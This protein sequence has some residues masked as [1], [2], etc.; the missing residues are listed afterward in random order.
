[1]PPRRPRRGLSAVEQPGHPRPPDLRT[2]LRN[3]LREMTWLGPSDEALMA[4]ALRVAEEIETAADRAE[5]LADLRRMA[6]GGD[7]ALQERLHR[8][9]ALC[10]VTKVVG[11]L[12]PQLQGLL[13]DL[14]GNPGARK[15]LQP[16]K[17]VGGRL[18]QLR[19]AASGRDE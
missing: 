3:A 9:E 7:D 10:E 17:P 5:E 6:S 15:V 12:G 11:W 2:T 1:M 13:R 19:A 16:D 4:L 18:A 14:G 8:L